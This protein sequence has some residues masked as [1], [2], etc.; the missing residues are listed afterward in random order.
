MIKA[1]NS[2][3]IKFTTYEGFYQNQ[4]GQSRDY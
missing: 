4:R 2:E 1:A 3:D